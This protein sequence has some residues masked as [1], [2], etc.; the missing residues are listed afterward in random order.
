MC[1]DCTENVKHVKAILTLDIY[2]HTNCVSQLFDLRDSQLNMLECECQRRCQKAKGQRTRDTD[3]LKRRW[4]LVMLHWMGD[5]SNSKNNS[6]SASV[7]HFQLGIGP[8][9]TCKIKVSQANALQYLNY[10]QGWIPSERC[11]KF[12]K[13]K[14]SE[15]ITLSW[16]IVTQAGGTE[17]CSNWSCWLLSNE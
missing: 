15:T 5:D 12:Q 1:S 14:K 9:K 4:L 3:T 16:E 2:Y 8:E 6:A 7:Q 13:K 17:S 10:Q 11:I